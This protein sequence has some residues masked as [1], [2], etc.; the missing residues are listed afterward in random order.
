MTDVMD[1]AT[2]IVLSKDRI[3]GTPGDFTVNLNEPITEP[4]AIA[5]TSVTLPTAINTVDV[6]NP[7]QW[8]ITEYDAGML[9]Q[10]WATFELPAGRYNSMDDIVASMNYVMNNTLYGGALTYWGEVIQVE[11]A[12]YQPFI[13]FRRVISPT[14]FTKLSFPS[15]NNN[16]LGTILGYSEGEQT[17][18][19]QDYD[20][21]TDEAMA[22]AQYPFDMSGGIHEVYLILESPDISDYPKKISTTDPLLNRMT[23]LKRIPVDYDKTM[24]IMDPKSDMDINWLTFNNLGCLSQLSL[25]IIGYSQASNAWYIMDYDNIVNITFEFKIRY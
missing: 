2:L 20:G 4:I 22:V 18:F 9:P 8:K 10:E 12:Q 19:V 3:S 13:Y 14:V 25:K 5:C 7:G 6:S 21:R 11:L 23:I 1:E 24:V 15:A 17:F 16:A